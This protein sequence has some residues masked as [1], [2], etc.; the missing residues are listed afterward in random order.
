MLSYSINVDQIKKLKKIHQMFTLQWENLDSFSAEK[1]SFIKRHSIISNIGASTRIENAVL[2]NVE[3]DWVDTELSK[4]G[5]TT[6]TEKEEYI[7]NKLSKDKERSIEEVAGYRDALKIVYDSYK[8][9]T[10]LKESDIKG[11][12]RELMQ[13]YSNGDHHSGNYKTQINSV[14]EINSITGK[15]RNVMVTADPGIITQTSMADLVRWYNETINREAWVLPVSVEF[16]FRF[17]AIHPF[18]DGN[19]RLSRLL[20][21]LILMNSEDEY[22]SN[23]IPYIALDRDIEKTRSEY[24]LVLRKCSGGLFSIDPTKYNYNYF[25]N[26][27]IKVITNSFDNILFYS[28]KFED[29]NSLSETDIKIYE[30][31]KE[32]PERNLQTKDIVSEIA[33]PR[34]TVIYSLNKLVDKKFLQVI[35]KGAGVRY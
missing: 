18:Q 9:F 3:I 31:F 29:Y 25:L 10:V 19:G 32:K 14:V 15:K 5:D 34:R 12:H 35:G 33:I 26:Y 17:L 24:Y 30:C 23:L 6:F 22:F 16:V 13:Y 28:Q 7:K 21:Q 8:D 27:M 2:T 1:K 20:F 11:L 4:E